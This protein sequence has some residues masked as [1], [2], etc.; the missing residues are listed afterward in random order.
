MDNPLVSCLCL[1]KNRREWLPKAIE[2]FLK[3]TYE[4]RE[5]VIVADTE[6]DTGGLVSPEMLVIFSPGVVGA[7]RN[8]G[9][10]AARG[11]IIAVWDD[12]DYSAPG[13]LAQQVSAMTESG[14]AVTAYTSMKFTDGP[15]W[16]QYRDTGNALATSL[17]FLRSWWLTHKFREI[18]CGQDEAFAAQALA[19]KQLL[20][21]GDLDLMYATNHPGNTWDRSRLVGNRASWTP[22]PD[23]EWK[24]GV[25]PA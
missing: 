16:W 11:K 9:C 21:H 17:C 14:K 2:C 25:C 4:N 20:R 10:S 6:V 23:F 24:D 22:L 1:T 5:L 8:A 12:D 13:R 19:A 15:R 7:K 18:Q 3:Q